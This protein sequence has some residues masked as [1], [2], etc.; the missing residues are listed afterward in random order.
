MA[1]A[2]V[3]L[4]RWVSQGGGGGAG[5]MQDLSGGGVCSWEVRVGGGRNRKE[6]VSEKV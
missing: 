4:S 5:E 1:A 3:D 2:K 6:K